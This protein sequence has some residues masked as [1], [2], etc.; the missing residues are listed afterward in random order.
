MMFI[1]P[2]VELL[3]K[4]R[5]ANHTPSADAAGHDLLSSAR[6]VQSGPKPHLGYKQ[7]NETEYSLQRHAN[8]Q[9]HTASQQPKISS[10]PLS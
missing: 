8:S 1:L 2:R 10:N 3:V 5:M 7:G 6:E 9:T 4:T